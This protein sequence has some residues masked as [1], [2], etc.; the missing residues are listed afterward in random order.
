MNQPVS[1]EKALSTK[2]SA[3]NFEKTVLPD[4]TLRNLV[5]LALRAPS[6]Y[7]LQPWRLVIVRD[8]AV[9]EKLRGVAYGQAKITESSATIVVVAQAPSQ[10][11]FDKICDMMLERGMEKGL[12]DSM[13]ASA[14]RSIPTDP[15]D[16]RVFLAK[17]GGLLGAHVL[18]AAAGLGL[19]A[20]PMGGFQEDGV[21]QLLGIPA[22]AMVPMIIVVGKAKAQ[23]QKARLDG[24]Q[25]AYL[26]KYGTALR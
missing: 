17:H 4:E 2:S 20:C 15:A 24:S 22:E 18:M 9:L 6:A 16:K 12:V 23:P 19:D 11:D 25:A 13:R 7:N 1:V 26:D 3:H 14:V 10:S 5:D 8:S 21:K